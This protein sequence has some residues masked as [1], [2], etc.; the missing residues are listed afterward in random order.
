VIQIQKRAVELAVEN[1]VVHCRRMRVDTT[2][3]ETNTHYPTDSSLL[4]DGTRVL[5]RAMKRVTALTGATGTKVRDRS[6]SVKLRVLDNARAARSK[7]PQS[8]D[9]LKQNYRKLLDA[10]GRVVGQAKRRGARCRCQQRPMP[11][12]SL[13]NC[14]C[15]C[16]NTHNAG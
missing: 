14:Q 8:Q 4:G 1:N 16:K 7:A 6:R 10:T 9:R 15:R 11:G 5:T 2:V 13:L 3:V 12:S